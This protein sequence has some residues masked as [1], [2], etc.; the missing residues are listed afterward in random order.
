LQPASRLSDPSNVD[1]RNERLVRLAS[2][3]VRSLSKG[4][5]RLSP[6]N[7]LRIKAQR[8]IQ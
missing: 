6:E 3:H 4:R 5:M 8:P 7:Q 1:G 2:M